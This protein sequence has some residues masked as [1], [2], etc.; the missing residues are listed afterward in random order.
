MGIIDNGS[1][2]TEEMRRKE[3]PFMWCGRRNGMRVSYKKGTEL[4]CRGSVEPWAGM[5]VGGRD[6][7]CWDWIPKDLVFTPTKSGQLVSEE[8]C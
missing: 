4:R 5:E 7:N 1:R 6:R 8:L 3:S 2:K